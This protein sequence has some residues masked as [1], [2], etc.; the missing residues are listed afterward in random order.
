MIVMVIINH[1]NKRLVTMMIV[2]IDQ[3]SNT[4][5]CQKFNKT[6]L[7]MI[8]SK[9]RRI[10]SIEISIMVPLAMIDIETIERI[11]NTTMVPFMGMM[12]I[13]G[14]L[15]STMVPFMMMIDIGMIGRIP[16]STMVPFMMMIDIGMIGRIPNSTM[17]PFMMMTDTETIGET[18]I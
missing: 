3:M 8:P 7:L 11:L 17:V 12:D 1:R 4:T 10:W 2:L 6:L 9:V 16:N 13:E 15:D 5:V 18:P 14:I